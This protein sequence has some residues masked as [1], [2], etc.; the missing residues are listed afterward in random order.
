MGRRTG[1]V[2]CLAIGACALS[3]CELEGATGEAARPVP[4]PSKADSL[5]SGLPM[6]S[7][8]VEA[9]FGNNKAV[10][11]FNPLPFAVSMDDCEVRVFSNGR[12]TAR[13]VGLEGVVMQPQGTAVVCS[14]GATAFD[15]C[16][17]SHGSL[18]FNGNDAV[19][20]ACDFGS[21]PTTLDVI[22][23]VGEDPGS[24]GWSVGGSAPVGTRDQTLRRSCS[25]HA[26][27][28][29]FT[30]SQW[31]AAGADAFDDLGAHE[32]CTI[33]EPDVGPAC[34]QGDDVLGA[35]AAAIF[36]GQDPRFE[37]DLEHT[38]FDNFTPLTQALLLEAASRFLLE[39]D[40]LTDAASA[41]AGVAREGSG[42][43]ER[44]TIR[45][46]QTGLDFDAV[47]YFANDAT[48]HS[49]VSLAGTQEPV[50]FSFDGEFSSCDPVFCNDGDLSLPFYEG[51]DENFEP[52]D[53]YE[54]LLHETVL[55]AFERRSRVLRS[56]DDRTLLSAAFE[57]HTGE[58]LTSSEALERIAR[59]NAGPVTYYFVGGPTEDLE[60]VVFHMGDAT[61]HG[62][63]AVED[64]TDVE[65]LTQ[66]GEVVFCA[67]PPA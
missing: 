27:D 5:T 23:V 55:A 20:L 45:D 18:S 34:S 53:R 51:L 49:A 65:L 44:F 13:R 8:Y 16:D 25:T 43:V 26:G 40:Q 60:G 11:L 29:T 22:G 6:I 54:I 33:D 15:H 67:P 14:A 64:S 9:S 7:E 62:M 28:D 56:D 48:S 63:L 47:R 21:G 35:S 19:E 39:A 36:G 42:Q 37:V 38:L 2:A 12:T 59:D 17:V 41:L 32:L 31:E 61:D 66:D 50:A 1:I 3:A 58:T 24:A 46:T 30:A 52:D 57:A 4:A 10:E